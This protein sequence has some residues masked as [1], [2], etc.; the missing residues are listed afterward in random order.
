MAGP[1]DVVSQEPLQPVAAA[2]G[3]G[4][5][6][7]SQ[8]P[9]SRSWA[10][11]PGEALKNAPASALN[12]GKALI[13]PIL[14]P[15]DTAK[16]LGSI[17]SG[18]INKTGRPGDL[19][20][21]GDAEPTIDE[22]VKRAQIEAPADAVAKFYKDRYGSVE[23]LKKAIATDPVGVA[24]DAAT[25]LTLGGGAVANAPGTV[26]KFG[27]AA[28]TVGRAIDPVNAVLEGT[29]LAGKGL[30]YVASAPLGRTTGVGGATIRQAAEAGLEG[31]E[32]A[33]VF[34]E[35]MRGADPAAMV[36][37]ADSA[38]DQMR[39]ARSAEY[40]TGM[41][42]V[43][44]DPAV[45]SMNPIINAFANTVEV[46]TFKGKTIN[47][48]AAKTQQD[49]LDVL[50]EWRNANPADYHTPAG[51]DALKQTIGDIRESTQPH[52]PSR[53]VADRVY[54]AV[55]KEI[56]AQA[57]QYSKTMASYAE[58]SDKLKQ[59]QKSFGRT[60]T[61]SDETAVNRLLATARNNVT[62][63]YSMK[64][65]MLQDLAKYE[66]QLPA[67]IAGQTLNSMA[68]RG[69]TANLAGT[70]GLGAA[71][72]MS[73]P[74]MLLAA[75]AFMPRVVGEAAYGTGAA[76]R[77]LTKIDKELV[78]KG[79]LLGFQAGRAEGLL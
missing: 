39:A 33:K 5:D 46:G 44:A 32:R 67:A 7:V 30:G 13:E 40:Q 56:E 34:R 50:T 72:V 35:N 10:D 26:G 70:G 76:L 15:V 9:V 48:S 65:K 57:P 74:G 3:G 18:F 58:A 66:P 1:W 43:R 14:H 25:V 11:V 42:G 73:N 20:R 17:A 31:G 63:N 69:L 52:T 27:Q 59:L 8:E 28:Q 12:F 49:I 54:N 79:G 75:P 37:M 53:V 24:A 45:L 55:K 41:A 77:P 29:R 19:L 23:G 60:A 16:A 36:D 64:Q 2:G 6:V 78:R 22:I 51:F 47:R 62:A 21:V 4:W 38:L 68:P 61:A 71:A